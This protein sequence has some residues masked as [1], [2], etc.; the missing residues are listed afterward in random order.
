V[1]IFSLA[2]IPFIGGAELAVK[3]I[4]DRIGSPRFD[5]R[6]EAGEISAK[7]GPASGWEFD[8]VTV[9]LDG[10]QP[11]T[12]RIGNITVHRVG[13]GRMSKYFFP[14]TALRFATQLHRQKKFDIAWAIMANQAG[15]AA[16][17]FK[18]R[19]PEVKY[20]LTLQEGDSLKSIWWRTWWMRP[21]YKKIYTTADT[22]QAIS[23]FLADRARKYGFA[24]TIHVIPNGVDIAHFTRPL[25]NPPSPMPTVITVSRLVEKNGIDTL[26]QAMQFVEGQL[27]ILGIGDQ[28]N[29]LRQLASSLSL[30][31]RVSF[32][33]HVDHR[34]LPGYLHQADVFV[35][36]SRSEGLG[37]AFLEAMAAGLPIVAT[38]VGGII[39]F[40]EDDK[41]GLFCQVNNPRSV[42]DAINRL[43]ADKQ[44]REN[45]AMNG[46]ALVSERYDWNLIAQ[47]IKKVFGI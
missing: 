42:A 26:I 4:T 28:E 11:T 27:L 29:K 40:L 36:P 41:T 30:Q 6:V 21:L 20:L 37:S 2:Y 18:K 45:I 22:I 39:D 9:N 5:N 33:G 8:L 47:Q 16:S 24:K 44:L 43:L 7:G 17:W 46:S 19:F 1:L 34:Q 32:V 23:T 13:R 38:P 10:K 25:T 14:I 15:L 31:N 35:R 3:E 12:E